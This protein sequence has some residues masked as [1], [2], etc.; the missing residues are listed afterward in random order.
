LEE[1]AL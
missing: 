1:E